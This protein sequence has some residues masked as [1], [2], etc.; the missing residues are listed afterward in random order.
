MQIPVRHLIEL[1]LPLWHQDAKKGKERCYVSHEG[2]LGV[3]IAI[4]VVACFIILI[5]FFHRLLANVPGGGRTGG[6][7]F[8]VFPV[9]LALA[10][11]GIG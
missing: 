7:L 11:L 5:T 9:D 2:S 10:P 3:I 1:L 8:K 6:D 4:F